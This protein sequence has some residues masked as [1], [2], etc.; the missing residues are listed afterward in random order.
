MKV[1]LEGYLLHLPL[2]VTLI[3]RHDGRYCQYCPASGANLFYRTGLDATTIIEGGEVIE[4][5]FVC[6]KVLVDNQL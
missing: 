5:L 1:A 3:V 2:Y 6:E 4:V